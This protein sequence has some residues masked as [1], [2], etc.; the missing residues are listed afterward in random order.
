MP[1]TSYGLW[2]L[3]YWDINKVLILK[4]NIYGNYVT[5]HLRYITCVYIKFCPV[6]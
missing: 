6:I 4:L 5:G 3:I 2:N 1:A